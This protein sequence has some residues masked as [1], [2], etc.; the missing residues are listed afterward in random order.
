MTNDLYFMTV[1]ITI[2]VIVGLILLNKIK[3]KAKDKHSIISWYNHL[4]DQYISI[5]E[6]LAEQFNEK[7]ELAEKYKDWDSSKRLNKL[8][9][10]TVRTSENIEKKLS[11]LK[12]S[13]ADKKFN[14]VSFTSLYNDLKVVESYV[15]EIANIATLVRSIHPVNRSNNFGYEY[16]KF[17]SHADPRNNKPWKSSRFF[18]SCESKEDLIKKYRQ[19]AKIYHPDNATTGNADSFKRLK[20]EY[21]EYLKTIQ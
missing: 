7:I 20:D 9:D 3:K 15:A 13:I 2:I 19:L 4:I 6:T 10:D 21:D 17:T 5:Y 16:E 1:I 11:S 14:G 18:A 12:T 8:Y